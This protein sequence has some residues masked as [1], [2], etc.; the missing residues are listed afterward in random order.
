MQ[1]WSLPLEKVVAGDIH[2]QLV[3]TM[4]LQAA[5]RL[6]PST[7]SKVGLHLRDNKGTNAEVV[8]CVGIDHG[9]V[10]ERGGVQVHA[11]PGAGQAGK[12]LQVFNALGCE[13]HELLKIVAEKTIAGMKKLR[14]TKT[15]VVKFKDLNGV[16]SAAS[17]TVPKSTVVFSNVASASA[18][19]TSPPAI[20]PPSV[21]SVKPFADGV[22]FARDVS[23][24]T[25]GITCGD[26][27]FLFYGGDR[28][29]AD[30]T[31]TSTQEVHHRVVLSGDLLFFATAQGRSGAS[32][33]WCLYCRTMRSMW[34][35]ELSA[36]SEGVGEQARRAPQ[37]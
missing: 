2:K 22:S 7:D 9:N 11:I 26:V 35:S 3:A 34:Q 24:S 1:F 14:E 29:N 18:P 32:N 25:R 37:F 23:G 31:I 28:I 21:P 17:V 13:S 16:P 30:S 33:Y 10:A 20:F 6:K 15:V 8:V 27:T 12:I 19:A 4:A 5:S 36:R